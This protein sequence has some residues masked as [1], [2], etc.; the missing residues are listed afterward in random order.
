[1]ATRNDITAYA[2]RTGQ[3]SGD[4][5]AQASEQTVTVAATAR[6]R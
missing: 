5:R 6:E 2:N 3:I 4:K 1:M